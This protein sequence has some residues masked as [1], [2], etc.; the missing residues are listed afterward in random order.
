MSEASLRG[1]SSRALSGLRRSP[2][3]HPAHMALQRRVGTVLGLVLGRILEQGERESKEKERERERRRERER[4]REGR[5]RGRRRGRGIGR[6]KRRGRGGEGM[7][8]KRRGRR[9]SYTEARGS[10]KYT[11]NNV[12]TQTKKQPW[13]NM[14]SH[15]SG[16]RMD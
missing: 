16:C 1:G 9:N 11:P 14:L 15:L 3:H 2:G 13:V 7:G 8:E 6:G 12:C 5:G 4:E 10:Q